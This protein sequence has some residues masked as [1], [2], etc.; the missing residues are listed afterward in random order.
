MT[1]EQIR[2]KAR[3]V[4]YAILDSLYPASDSAKVPLHVLLMLVANELNRVVI[5]DYA[6][7]LTLRGLLVAA[8]SPTT[9]RRYVQ[10]FTKILQEGAEADPGVARQLVIDYPDAVLGRRASDYPD[11][12]PEGTCPSCDEIRAERKGQ[13]S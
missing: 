3:D 12:H 7:R 2:S 5:V 6:A 13:L 9:A 11:L 1:E 10:I 4:L 8:E